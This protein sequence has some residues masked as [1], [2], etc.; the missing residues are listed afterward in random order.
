MAKL[1]GWLGGLVGFV[2]WRW[3]GG[4]PGFLV[5]VVVASLA[6]PLLIGLLAGSREGSPPVS[7][8]PAEV[9]GTTHDEVPEK[10]PAVE[11]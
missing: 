3:I 6:S 4:V 7:A 2:I 9:P 8:G 11:K 5:G 1:G 10:Y